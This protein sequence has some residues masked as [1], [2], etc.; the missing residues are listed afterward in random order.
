[1]ISTLHFKYWFEIWKFNYFL[2]RNLG[3]L[4]SIS[5]SLVECLWMALLWHLSS[6]LFLAFLWVFNSSLRALPIIYDIL[7]LVRSSRKTCSYGNCCFNR[8]VSNF[9][10]ISS[11][12]Q[13]TA[14]RAFNGKHILLICTTKSK[15][16]NIKKGQKC[17]ES[18]SDWVGDEVI[19]W[20]KLLGISLTW[21]I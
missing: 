18:P 17:M 14:H 3:Y 4:H 15:N 5:L 19:L 20:W 9:K 16:L 12:M 13:Q 8:I 21:H 6:F 11:N 7:L 2:N 10:T 1:M